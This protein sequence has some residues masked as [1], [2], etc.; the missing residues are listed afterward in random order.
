MRTSPDH[1]AQPTAEPPADQDRRTAE[2][3]TA[4]HERGP[5]VQ[6][7]NPAAD[8]SA[9]P[10]DQPAPSW[11]AA[12]AD[13][14]TADQT[15]EPADQP[16]T[17]NTGAADQS[18]PGSSEP[19][20]MERLVALARQGALR[21]GR[22]TRRAIRPYLREHGIQISNERFGELQD[23]LYRDAALARLPRPQKKAL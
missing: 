23:H 21:E 16:R 17:T 8:Q 13:Q 9:H 1:A 14:T 18:G 7:T 2:E 11:S 4:D 10:A 12:S 3:R 20:P 5:A 15:T 22:L 6:R 19:V